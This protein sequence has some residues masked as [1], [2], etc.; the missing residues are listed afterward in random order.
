M[1]AGVLHDDPEEA[2]PPPKTG[3]KLNSREVELLRKWIAQG[4]KFSRH[5]AFIPPVRPPTAKT[6]MTNWVRSPLDS[7]VLAKL[8]REGLKPSAEADRATWLRR[9]SFDLTGLPPTVGELD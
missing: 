3:K 5:W 9:V 6:R 7:F 2:M 8:E 4:A 1:R